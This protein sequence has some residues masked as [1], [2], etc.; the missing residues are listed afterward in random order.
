MRV[1]IKSEEKIFKGSIFTLVNR[2]VEFSN[3]REAKINVIEHPGAVA[4]IPLFDNEDLL[5]IK[6]LRPAIGDEIYEIPAGTLEK[7]ET[8]LDCAKR[9]TIEEVGYRAGKFE[10]LA[11]FFIAPGYSTEKI[12]LF[13]ATELSPESASKSDRDEYIEPVR[14]PLKK[15]LNMVQENKIQDAKSIA[16]LF[17]VW[18]KIYEK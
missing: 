13:L 11:E 12:H 1:K 2:I 14:L 7:G 17:F 9:E 4:I 15:A 18:K 6:Q 3:G 16:G 8:P 5:L 10:K